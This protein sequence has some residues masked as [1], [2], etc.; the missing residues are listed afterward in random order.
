MDAG[1]SADKGSAIGQ[2]VAGSGPVSCHFSF[3][4]FTF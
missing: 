4:P 3:D 1:G 2:E